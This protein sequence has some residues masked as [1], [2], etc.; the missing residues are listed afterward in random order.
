[1]KAGTGER[2]Q[3]EPSVY[4]FEHPWDAY[5]WAHKIEWEYKEPA[6]IIKL[7]RSD[8]WEKDPTEDFTLQGGSGKPLMS[9]VS[10]PASDIV[11]AKTKDQLGTPASTEL[12]GDDFEQHVVDEF[13]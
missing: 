13:S 9:R 6:V 11:G 10:I 5:R 1:M 3:D 12:Y 2:Y 4:A 7:K 8:A